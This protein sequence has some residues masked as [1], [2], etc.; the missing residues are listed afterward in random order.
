MANL[1]FVHAHAYIHL[2]LYSF[3]FFFLDIIL[4]FCFVHYSTNYII[5]FL[6]QISFSV[7]HFTYLWKIIFLFFLCTCS[8]YLVVSLVDRA[9]QKLWNAILTKGN[10]YL[11]Q[12]NTYL[13]ILDQ[14]LFCFFI[15]ENLNQTLYSGAT[16][17]DK[18]NIPQYKDVTRGLVLV[19]PFYWQ[20]L[21]DR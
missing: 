17:L 1:F 3:F 5:F 12:K 8:R 18:N 7:F 9:F 10:A 16:Q 19:I 14:F 11:F 20:L 15:N 6:T 2:V 21:N 13:R 4:S